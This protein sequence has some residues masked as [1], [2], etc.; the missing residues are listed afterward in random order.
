[1][2]V[3]VVR[4]PLVEDVLAANAENVAKYRAGKTQVLNAILGQVMKASAGKAN[5]A[6][7]RTILEERLKQ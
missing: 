7:V 5:P 6:L 1:M 4:H 3:H 2:N